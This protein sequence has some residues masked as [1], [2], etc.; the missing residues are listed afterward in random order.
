V[1]P[2]MIRRLAAEAVG[3]FGFFFIG[4]TGVAAGVETGASVYVP[5]GFGFG[6]AMMI[7]ALGHIS[8]GHFNPAVTAGLSAGG[9]FPR[10]EVL[11]YWVAQLA[12]GLVAAFA[13]RI[14]YSGDAADKIVTA[15]GSGIS[16]GKALVVELLF[17][18]LFLLVVATVATDQRAP[19]NG[20]FAP[21]AIGLFIFTAAAVAGPISGGSFN[22]AISLA[23]AI[24]DADLSNVW[25]YLIGP[26]AGGILGG[27]I[28]AYFRDEPAT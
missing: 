21:L 22:P 12:G 8:G 3:T 15:P 13:V 6:L 26:L 19:W 25:I 1:Q 23:P 16:S 18:L 17:T 7:F 5:I 11:P 24:A 20:I 27:L 14:V 9:R 2:E 10:A 28:H 4:Y